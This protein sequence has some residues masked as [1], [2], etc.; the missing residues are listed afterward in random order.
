MTTTK[1]V[2][3]M[4]KAIYFASAA[5]VSL[6]PIGALAQTVPADDN[7]LAEIVVTAQRRVENLQNVS[8]AA[9]A[10]SGEQLQ[11]KAIARLSDLE[12]AS[13]SLS[14]TD[15]GETQ[16]VNI[17]G[18]GLSS[19]L[20]AV[21][22]GVATYVDGLFQVQIV[23]AVPFYDI[24]SVEVL[25]GPQGTLVG[26]NSTGGAIF[27][28]TASPK[29]GQ[30]GGYAQA[31]LGNYDR[32]EAEGAVSIPLGETLAIR[33]AGIYRKRD[34]FYTD[35]GPYHNKAGKLDEKG[36][37]LGVLWKPGQFQANLKLQLHEGES[38]GF[39]YRP[40]AGTAFAPFLV[41][42]E[43]TLSYDSPTS[44][45]EKAFQAAL[46]LQYEFDNG[47]TLTSLSGYQNKRNKYL[48][49]TDA[50]QAPI[51]PTGG[52]IVDYYAR[53]KQFS[54]EF[55]L[56]SPT[57]ARFDWILGAY[58]QRNDI[59]VDFNQTSPTPSVAYGPRQKRDIWGVFG[60]GNYALS[61]ALELQVGLRYSRVET[62]GTGGVVL[63]A[64]SPGFPP[65]GIVVADLSGTHEDSRPTGKVALNWTLDNDNLI[66]GF[67]ARG[68]KPGGF[69]SSFSEFDPE[70]VWDYEL[71]WKSTL[72]DGR[73]RTQLSAFYNDYTGL[74]IDVLEAAT[75]VA[76]VQNV[77]SAT[78]KGIEAQIQGRFGG[79]GFDASVGYVDSE[80][81]SLTFIN[82]RL[83]PPGNLGPQCPAGV[84][85][86]PGVCFNYAPFVVT[87]G[88]GPNL[89]A[90]KTTYSLGVEYR[91][92]L[93]TA[94][95]TP[96]LNYGYV[97]AR[98]NYIAYG[99]NDR[100]AS[101]GLLSA[102]ITYERDQWRVEAFGT[103]LADKT[104]VS[105]RSGDNE[106]YGAPRE[107]GV[108]LG[109]KF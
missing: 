52:F 11:K 5:L 69:N 61:E 55:N 2:V 14:I 68:Y 37:R 42:D 106:F 45:S 77:G 43:R 27:I 85:P 107:Y 82:T 20:P 104:F 21:T 56:I 58:Y 67:V 57:D 39:A 103:N 36:A 86:A 10:I 98:Y 29:L 100:L 33:A 75:G 63:G 79:L 81:S 47:V 90:P 44:Q 12:A 89:Y 53:D 9:T 97:G 96:R 60:Q 62:S 72:A 22:N 8:I 80:L 101:R 49:D 91:F 48:Q 40:V 26:N 41:G 105:G 93:G 54:Q 108:R 7:Q 73:I 87:N 70:T 31:A 95:L 74:Q 23:S 84:T 24:S 66:Y 6:A 13:P 46:K 102:L 17:R 32:V 30:T 51:S 35:V 78:I 64:G 1:H 50:S 3:P 18:I 88:G 59:F 28:N 92:D 71:G 38:G 34:S 4:R 99:P 16:S 15:A 19:N 109:V 76:A 65:S 94:T 25:R 83:L